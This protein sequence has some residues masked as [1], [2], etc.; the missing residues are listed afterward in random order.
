MNNRKETLDILRAIAIFLVLGNHFVL[1][2]QH[3]LYF[4]TLMILWARGGWVGVDIFFVLSGFLIAGLLFKEQQRFGAIS[5][6][7]FFIRRGFKIYPA[8]YAMILISALMYALWHHR[9]YPKSLIIWLFFLQDYWTNQYSKM[10]G[11]TWSLAV[12]EQFYII[13]PILLIILTKVNNSRKD[14]FTAIPFL[15]M[16]IGLVCLGARTI[17]SFFNV[18]NARNFLIPFHL[19]ADALFFGVLISYFYHYDNPKFKRFAS[20]PKL[21]FTIGLLLL[22]PAFI[23]GIYK[24]PFICTVGFTLFYIGSGLVLV[25]VVDKKVRSNFFTRTV[26]TI[27]QC[28]YSIYL[29]HAIIL[30][31]RENLSTWIFHMPFNGVGQIVIYFLGSI[32]LGIL[33]TKIIEFPLLRLRDRFFSS[34]SAAV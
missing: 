2:P 21:I 20:R 19:R 4:R 16:T 18:L 24:T 11:H 9:F 5:F 17:E 31:N 23:F 33:M 15:F 27:G 3:H 10:W 30:L 12:E 8:F 32:L 14:P 25:A 7:R 34:R 28:S 13:L 6:Q 22:I 29:W 1:I 26:I